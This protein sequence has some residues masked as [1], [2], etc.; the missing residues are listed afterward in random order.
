M[1]FRAGEKAARNADFFNSL[2]AKL[3]G[4]DLSK[5][6][7]R[8]INE[9]GSDYDDDVGGPTYVSGRDGVALEPVDGDQKAAAQQA[10]TKLYQAIKANYEG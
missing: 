6:E 3:L 7:Y 9:G 5:D 1:I 4:T 10:A 2:L 8:V